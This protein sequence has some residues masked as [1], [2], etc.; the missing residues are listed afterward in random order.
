[1]NFLPLCTA[2]VWPIISG[3]MV[4]RRDHVFTTFF[5]FRALSASTLFRRGASTNGPFFSERPIVLPRSY[6]PATY[7]CRSDGLLIHPA[8]LDPLGAPHFSK[9]AYRPGNPMGMRAERAHEPRALLAGLLF[10]QY[11]PSRLTKPVEHGFQRNRMQFRRRL[12][13]GLGHS[14]LPSR[15]AR[16][17][18]TPSRRYASRCSHDCPLRHPP[19]R[20]HDWFR[21]SL[22][23][24]FSILLTRTHCRHTDTFTSAA[25]R[26][27]DRCGDCVAS[28]RPGS[29]NPKASWGDCP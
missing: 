23:T 26:S 20:D 19:R 4:E 25:P 29:E 14:R 13:R 8:Q 28:W 12:P 5:S 24:T 2:M 17:R 27:C 21:P 1:M 18:R 16:V 15:L 10:H 22:V 11:R 9:T 7:P 3:T 6:W